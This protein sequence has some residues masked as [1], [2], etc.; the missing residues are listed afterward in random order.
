MAW[1]EAS[2][3]AALADVLRVHA[4]PYIRKLQASSPHCSFGWDAM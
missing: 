3:H 4:W 2:P 1:D